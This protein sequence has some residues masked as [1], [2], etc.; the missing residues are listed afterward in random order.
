MNVSYAKKSF[1]ITQITQTH[2]KES[3]LH[4][5]YA[6]PIFL[7]K[8][9]LPDIENA[10]SQYYDVNRGKAQIQIYSNLLNFCPYLKHSSQYPSI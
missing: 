5:S 8:R 7:A 6:V 4:V 2:Q 10:W 9:L 1:S 3:K